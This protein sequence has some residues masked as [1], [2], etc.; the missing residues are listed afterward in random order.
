MNQVVNK[1]VIQHNCL[2]LRAS[3]QAIHQITKKKF[4]E[5]LLTS[6]II[7]YYLCEKINYL[8]AL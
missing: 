5:Q 4:E 3:S 7:R 8:A 2:E 1:T 6:R